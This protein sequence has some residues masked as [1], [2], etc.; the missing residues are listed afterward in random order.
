MALHSQGEYSATTIVRGLVIHVNENI[1]SIVT[2]LT[3]GVKWG[4]ENITKAIT[5]KRN[6]FLPEENLVEDKNG[7]RRESLPYSWDEVS[8]TILK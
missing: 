4:N 7:V 5:G 6:L 1:I 2:T 8:Y 3:L